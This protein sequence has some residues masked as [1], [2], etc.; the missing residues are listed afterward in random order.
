MQGKNGDTYTENSR[1]DRDGKARVGR[2]EKTALTY[3]HF[4]RGSAV[5]IPPAVKEA[6]VQSL[7]QIIPWRMECQP[8]PVFFPGETMDCGHKELDKTE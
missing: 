6:Q 7:G 3:I 5:K 1:V 8:T 4:A 2:T